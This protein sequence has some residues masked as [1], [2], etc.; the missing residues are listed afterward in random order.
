MLRAHTTNEFFCDIRVSFGAATFRWCYTFAS[1]DRPT[2][3][4]TEWQS[5]KTYRIYWDGYRARKNE[6]CGMWSPGNSSNTNNNDEESYDWSVQRLGFISIVR[7]DWITNRKNC[8]LCFICL[9]STKTLS[10]THTHTHLQ[11]KWNRWHRHTILH[12]MVFSCSIDA[13]F[14]VETPLK[15]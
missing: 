13:T 10:N 6:M 12:F 4:T 3:Q 8:A 2:N 11:S 5:M 15:L 1:T 14:S 9:T 7:E